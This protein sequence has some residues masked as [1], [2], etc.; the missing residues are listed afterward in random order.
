MLYCKNESTTD[1]QRQGRHRQLLR[2]QYQDAVDVVDQRTK[3][4]KELYRKRQ[5]IVEHPFGTVKAIWGYKQ[6]LCRG[7]AKVSAEV[8][9]AYLAYNM[10]RLITIFTGK[11]ENPAAVL[12]QL[13]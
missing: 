12:G 1:I 6:F 8:A 9:M 5:E 3:E 7:K 13:A 2:P 10:R 11:G 4:N